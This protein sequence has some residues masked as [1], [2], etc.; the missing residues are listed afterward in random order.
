MAG[1]KESRAKGICG[2]ATKDLRDPPSTSQREKVG[3]VEKNVQRSSGWLEFPHSAREIS[4]Q[5]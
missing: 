5:V 1:S 3:G 2:T 4:K